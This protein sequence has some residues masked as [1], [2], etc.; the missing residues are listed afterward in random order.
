MIIYQR[1]AGAR[2]AA[3][4]KQFFRRGLSGFLRLRY[5]CNIEI[6]NPPNPLNP[7]LKN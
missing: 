2:F 3:R 5:I 4:C 6:K 7:R 1:S